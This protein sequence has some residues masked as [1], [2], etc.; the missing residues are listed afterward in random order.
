MRPVEQ[1][2]TEPSDYAALSIAYGSLLAALAA[3]A[4]ATASRSRPS[5]LVPLSAATF[6]LSKLIVR[7]KA[8]TWIRRPFVEEDRGEPRPRGRGLRYAIGELLTCT[9][10]TGAWSAL[11]LV[12]LRLHAPA[13]GRH[14]H[15]GARRLGR[16]RPAPGRL[17]LAVRAGDDPAARGAGRAA[18]PRRAA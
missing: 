18:S 7:E 11:A 8:E 13:H 4:R 10:C 5:E 2:P 6:A 9:R 15:G 14:G 3:V 17:H 1:T 12:G 16:Q